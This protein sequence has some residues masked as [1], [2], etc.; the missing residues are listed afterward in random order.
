MSESQGSGPKAKHQIGEERRGKGPGRVGERQ[1]KWGPSRREAGS[2]RGGKGQ[3]TS[4]RSPIG[5][6]GRE[7]LHRDLWGGEKGAL[8]PGDRSRGWAKE[9]RRRRKPGRSL[10]GRAVGLSPP[11]S[12]VLSSRA[13][14]C[15]GRRLGRSTWARR[16]PS[17]TR[18]LLTGKGQEAKPRARR[19]R[20]PEGE[21]GHSGSH[22]SHSP[23][24]VCGR[25]CP[26]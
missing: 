25:R 16:R 1:R 13:N 7:S 11:P 21:D 17:A 20:G 10:A 14:G 9:N 18:P 5:G 6:K 24:L 3:R 2:A 23:R 8:E 15:N 4:G 22:A 19:R 12:C 26:D